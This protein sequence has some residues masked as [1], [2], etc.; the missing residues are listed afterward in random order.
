MP[1]L[2]HGR[3]A[4]GYAVLI[5]G[6]SSYTQ[7]W[8]PAA[9]MAGAPGLVNR[10]N[11][12]E[13][14]LGAMSCE[15]KHAMAARSLTLMRNS[16]PQPRANSTPVQSIKSDRITFKGWG[17]MGARLGEVRGQSIMPKQQG[18]CRF[19]GQARRWGAAYP[20]AAAG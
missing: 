4:R 10:K 12:H 17:R 8:P 1:V 3:R 18:Y 7:Q 14:Q 9:T 13:V 20:T 2:A 16:H 19:T 11:A 6:P 15:M 5:D